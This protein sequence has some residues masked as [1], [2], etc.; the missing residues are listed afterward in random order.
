MK[1]SSISHINPVTR[2]SNFPAGFEHEVSHRRAQICVGR[3]SNHMKVITHK[4]EGVD[5]YVE[6]AVK[7]IKMSGHDIPN[8]IFV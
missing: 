6:P 2:V 3:P 4:N 8:K 5:F 7:K 1:S